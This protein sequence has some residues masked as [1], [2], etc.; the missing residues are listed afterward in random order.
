[1]VLNR[2]GKEVFGADLRKLQLKN[3]LAKIDMFK[4]KNMDELVKAIRNSK[5]EEETYQLELIKIYGETLKN[6]H[7]KLGPSGGKKLD[8]NSLIDSIEELGAALF[9]TG[10]THGGFKKLKVTS[11]ERI[12]PTLIREAAKEFDNKDEDTIEASENNSI[13]KANALNELKNHPAPFQVV[14]RELSC[15]RNKRKE[16]VFRTLNASKT[17]A[18]FKNKLELLVP[19]K[20]YEPLI[21]LLFDKNGLRPELKLTFDELKIRMKQSAS[22]M[23]GE[24]KEG[25]YSVGYGEDL[26]D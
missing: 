26:E 4:D 19:K 12:S 21:V 24:S 15:I 16:A 6:C 1:V 22:E 2:E 18:E 11:E 13:S 5:I 20:A 8:N 14:R 9:E 25:A 7:E 17:S 23:A 3:A 10:K